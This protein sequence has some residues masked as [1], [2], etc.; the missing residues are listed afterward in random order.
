MKNIFLYIAVA[1]CGAAVLALEILGTRIL[2][3][4]YGVSLFL[5]SAL[6]TVT[7][8]ALSLGYLIGGRSADKRA[9]Y[10]KFCYLIGIAGLWIL[11]IPWIKSPFLTL[12]APLGLRA[13]VIAA[14]FILFF[15]PLTLLGMI[16]PYAIKLKVDS[17]EKVG[18]TAGNLYAISTI[19]SVFS[20]LLTGFFFIPIIGVNRLTIS[21]GII[22]IIFAGYGLYTQ[23]KRIIAI[24]SFIL[25]ILALLLLWNSSAETADQN[26]NI[27]T[28]RQSQYGEISVLDNEGERYLLIDGGIHSAVDTTS[29]N[30]ITHYAAV[31]DL[32]KF[33]FGHPGNALLIGLGGGSLL[34]QYASEG[35]IMDAVEI[36]PAV[37]EIAHDHFGLSDKEGNIFAMDGRQFLST[38]NRK[39]DVILLDAFGSSSIPFHLVT[40][41]V[42]GLIARHLTE[43][44]ILAVNVETVGW[45]DPIVITLSAT[46]KQKFSNILALPMEEPPDELGNVVILAANRQLDPLRTPEENVNFDPNWRYGPGYQ[47]LHAW[48]NR[49]IPD[50][51]GV[52]VLTDDLNPIDI[53]SEI[54]NLE[55]RK[56]LHSLFGDDGNN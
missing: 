21:V 55:A 20:A 14:A 53:R 30:S 25:V 26:S 9:T 54:I 49:F 34:K 8:A 40:E 41:E 29:W 45:H 33:F 42:F 47:K 32:P 13:A 46:L 6:I 3:P 48:D 16:S 56:K 31:M 52:Q 15:P 39:Y 18:R 51:T 50:I 2:G 10:S 38:T 23:K 22:L 43:G 7:L 44:G 36:D 27:V 4:F 1:L 12:T 11:L 19:A 28:V 35:W 37:I 5:W 24:A 17:M